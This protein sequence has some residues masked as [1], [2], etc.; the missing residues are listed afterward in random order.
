MRILL[1]KLAEEMRNEIVCHLEDR[2][3]ANRRMHQ[4]GSLSVKRYSRQKA[5][6]ANLLSNKTL[7]EPSQLQNQYLSPIPDGLRHQRLLTQLSNLESR[8]T[9]V[10]FPAADN[11]Q[12]PM[13]KLAAS[14]HNANS[15]LKKQVKN[16]LGN[17]R[18]SLENGYR[19]IEWVCVSLTTCSITIFHYL[20]SARIVANVY[21]P[22]L[23][24]N[25]L[26]P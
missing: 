8:L 26:K 6:P 13:Y 18:P 2:Y 19:R 24:T 9:H 5:E 20:T 17:H 16:Y 21:G 11:A 7:V 15:W 3:Q 14:V 12:A 22:I 1:L 25:T 4:E 10:L 23:T